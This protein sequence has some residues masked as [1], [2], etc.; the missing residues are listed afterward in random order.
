[1]KELH[2]WTYDLVDNCKRISGRPLIPT[3][4]VNVNKGDFK[5]SQGRSRLCVGEAKYRTT[6][7]PH[8]AAAVCSATPPYEALRFLLSMIMTPQTQQEAN[9]VVMF[10]DISRA[11]PHC[12][13]WSGISGSSDLK[14]I[15]GPQSHEFVVNFAKLF[16][17]PETLVNALSLPFVQS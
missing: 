1:M 17:D 5:N 15:H 9:H 14:R 16:T 10:I 7:D 13:K 4:W 6:S 8:D 12:K 2:V 11:Y 3:R